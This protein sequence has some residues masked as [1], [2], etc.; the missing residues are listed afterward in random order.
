MV[1]KH[2]L[3]GHPHACFGHANGKIIG[4]N[5]WFPSKPCLLT[6]RCII[7]HPDFL[8]RTQGEL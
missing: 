4:L 2:A 7:F 6:I 5:E 1:I 8:E 3:L